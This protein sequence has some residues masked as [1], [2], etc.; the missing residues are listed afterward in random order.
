MIFILNDYIYLESRYN[1]SPFS[2]L[3]KDGV[4]MKKKLAKLIDVKSILTLVVTSVFAYLSIIG[5]ITSENFMEIFK[6]IVIFYFG[7]QV[8]KREAKEQEEQENGKG[9]T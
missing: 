7:S 8:G 6:L 3:R 4:N 5:N 1:C 9:E 2:F